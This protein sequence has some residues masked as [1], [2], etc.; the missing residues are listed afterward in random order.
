MNTFTCLGCINNSLRW[1]FWNGCGRSYKYKYNLS[2]HIRKECGVEPQ[3]S[4][5]ICV[6]AFKQNDHL[7]WHIVMRKQ[8]NYKNNFFSFQIVKLYRLI[9]TVYIY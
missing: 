3:Y 1:P 8:L 5:E 6:R 7:T 2:R 4:C 9:M